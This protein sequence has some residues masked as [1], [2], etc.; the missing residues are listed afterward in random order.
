MTEMQA[1]LYEVI[2][3]VLG[4]ERRDIASE[5]RFDEDFQADSLD[6]VELVM[7]L[8]EVFGIVIADE[9]A[10]KIKTVGDAEKMVETLYY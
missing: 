4:V 2:G 7:E 9:D 1:K 6:L 5:K 3:D 8:E 10:E